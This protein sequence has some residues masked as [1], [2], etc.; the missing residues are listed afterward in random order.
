MPKKKK[1]PVF[2]TKEDKRKY[3]AYKHMHIPGCRGKGK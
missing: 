1:M 2:K 3:E